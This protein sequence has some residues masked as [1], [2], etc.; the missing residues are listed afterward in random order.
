[1]VIPSS[2]TE[3]TMVRK[4][5]TTVLIGGALGLAAC[6]TVRGVGQDLGTA[7]NCTENTIQG[8]RC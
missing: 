1:M 7:A 6:N 5:V 4:L 3:M 2:L 8:S